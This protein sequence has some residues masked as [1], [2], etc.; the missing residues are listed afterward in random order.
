MPDA[1]SS[2]AAIA[3]LCREYGEGDLAERRA[4]VEALYDLARNGDAGIAGAIPALMDALAEPDEKLGE[5]ALWALYKCMPASQPDLRAALRHP[6]ALVRERAAHSLGTAGRDALGAAPALR[7][8]LAD[9]RPEVRARAAW[10]LGLIGDTSADALDLLWRMV[11]H[12]ATTDRGA[13]LHALGNLGRALDDP[14]AFEPHRALVIAALDDADEDVRWSALFAC[15]AL[16]F[17]PAEQ[18][19]M[20][21]GLLE[22]PSPRVVE[23]V[24]RR[25]EP[26]AT[27]VDLSPWL[28]A[29]LA[30]LHGPC[31]RRVCELLGEMKPPPLQAVSALQALFHDDDRALPAARALWRIQPDAQA[32]VNVLERLILI[33]NEGVCDLICEM[34]PAAAPLLPLVLEVLAGDS[35]DAQWAAADALAAIAS[36]DA[37]TRQALLKALDHASPLVRS[38]A[39]RALAQ[40]GA[41]A[42]PVLRRLVADTADNRCAW[43]AYALGL[44]GEAGAEGLGELRRG[45]AAGVEPLSS[46]CAI[47]MAEIGSAESVPALVELL[48]GEAG[49]KRLAVAH[50]LGRLGPAAAS[51]I[52]ALR[53]ASVSTDDE[54]ASVALAALAEVDPT[55]H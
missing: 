50:A 51:A 2:A 1:E 45:L 38:G 53:A 48:A 17:A 23:A 27:G 12:G 24:L 28:G 25:L 26:L 39:S 30:R 54:F 41:A 47:A 13:A 46:A 42:V 16:A 4:A 52:P 15:S 18:A 36:S 49:S 31:A 35:W 29:L 43:A 55:L 11:E 44:M 3:R 22:D 14:A 5:S 33:D 10:A 6:A 34:G 40:Q 9:D 8:L 19:R 7:P 37:E 20:L 21:G 32:L